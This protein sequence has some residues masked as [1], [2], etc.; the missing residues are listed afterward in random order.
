M[1]KPAKMA[2]WI[3]YKGQREALEQLAI[4]KETSVAQLTRE[5]VKAYLKKESKQCK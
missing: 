3:P 4:E 5:A 1:T 2:P